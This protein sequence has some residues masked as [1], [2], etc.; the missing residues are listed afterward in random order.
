MDPSALDLLICST[1]GVQYDTTSGLKSCKICDDP[2]QYVPPSGQSWATL[3]SLQ[4]SP[5][6]YRNVFT[7]D[8]ENPNLISIQTAPKF[9]IGQRAFLCL[10]G[11]GFGNILWDCITYL[12]DETIRHINSLG[13]IRAIVISHP[14]YFSTSIQWA[15]AFNCDLYISAEDEEWVANRGDGH[16][17]KLWKGK[18][19]FLPSQALD[20][21]QSSD[22]VAIK[23]GGH[24]PGSSV[25][26]WKSAKKLLI[27][28]TIMIVPSG[29]YRVD[30]PPGTVSY[31]FMWSY[32]NYIP[33]PPD[34]VHGIWKAIED[35]DFEDTHGAFT[36]QDAR[37]NIFDRF[38]FIQFHGSLVKDGKHGGL[39]AARLLIQ[40]VQDHIHKVDPEA[41]P[42]ISCKIRVFANIEGLTE[43]YRN[44]N[45]LSVEESLTSFIQGFNQENALCDFVDAG[46]GKECADV[47]LRACFEQDI[48]DVHCRRIIFCASA[49]NSHARVLSPHRGSK[50][51]SLVKG[52][53]FAQEMGELAAGFTTDSF[54]NVFMANKLKTTRRVSFGAP[55]TTATPPRTPTPNY[56]AAAKATPPTQTSSVVVSAPANGIIRL[57]Q[58]DLLS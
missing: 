56:A 53:P 48:I 18:R 16:G 46:N 30:R 28:D 3:R 9:A 47:K 45:I 58:W 35:I 22:F 55:N 2:R 25:L 6:K 54:E 23:T 40:A 20:S 51:I 41:P 37:G 31:S 32:P 29:L 34:D 21:A 13:G 7:T 11:S 57:S 43:A 24:F 39:E 8:P 49:D 44:N 5:V 10:D 17:L 52:P 19:L 26:W 33:L 15:D 50:R 12:D 36:G 38:H 4:A 1:C 27:A 14:H 42:N